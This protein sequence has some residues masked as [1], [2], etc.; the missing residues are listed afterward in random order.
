MRKTRA[1]VFDLGGIAKGYAV[2]QA[3]AVLVRAGIQSACINAGGDLRVIGSTPFAV[4]IRDPITITNAAREV[5]IT[6]QAMATSAPYFSKRLDS[7]ETV[8]A[9][10]DGRDGRAMTQLQSVSV[11]AP[12]CM[13]ADAMTKIVIASRN[14][15]HPLLRQFNAKAFIIAEESC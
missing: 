8:C 4:S 11:I 7:N 3:I 10:V 12:S 5:T 14:A 2:D 9:L 1:A 6:D 15:L 13:I